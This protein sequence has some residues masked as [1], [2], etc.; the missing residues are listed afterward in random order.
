MRPLARRRQPAESL[1]RTCSPEVRPDVFGRQKHT[2]VWGPPSRSCSAIPG[3][4]CAES[5]AS[6]VTDTP[7]SARS[8]ERSVLAFPSM[9]VHYVL[10][11]HVFYILC[12][13]L[14]CLKC[15][16]AQRQTFGVCPLL[17]FSAGLAAERLPSVREFSGR[18][19]EPEGLSAKSG[20]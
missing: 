12:K 19:P 16:P 6:A 2:R 4:C 9:F 15:H 17:S 18:R 20:R 5:R 13:H 11:F 14:M 10:I 7:A 8:T 3:L 1:Q